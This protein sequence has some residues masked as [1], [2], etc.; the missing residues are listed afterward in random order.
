MSANSRLRLA[1][2]FCKVEA[3][4]QDRMEAMAGDPDPLV[5]YQPAFSLGALPGRNRR[6]A[7]AALAVRDGADPWMRMA[8]LSSVSGCAGEVFGQ[9]AGNAAFRDAAH[10]RA[11]LTDAGCPDRSQRTSGRS[12]RRP[13]GGGWPA[14][15]RSGPLPRHCRRIA[16]PDAGRG[17]GQV[18]PEPTPARSGSSLP[19]SWPTPAAP[20][21]TRRNGRR[22]RR[23]RPLLAVRSVR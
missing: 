14:G 23:G 1:E 11:F 19:G 5:R 6:T 16:E 15:R 12:G 9:L 3:R 4:V 13:Q 8:I 10:G 21:S 18:Q 20:R 22:T 2:P 17:A 7:L